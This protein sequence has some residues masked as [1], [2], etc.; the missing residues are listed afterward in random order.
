ML[1]ISRKR[2]KKSVRYIKGKYTGT[3][4]ILELKERE[5]LKKAGYM[6]VNLNG[7]DIIYILTEQYIFR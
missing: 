7:L 1:V 6:F 2:C 3:S 4:F 5:K